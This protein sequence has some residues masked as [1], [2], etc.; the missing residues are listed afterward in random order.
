MS[1]YSLRYE[2]ERITQET[3]IKPSVFFDLVHRSE[4]AVHEEFN[5]KRN[6]KNVNMLM[7]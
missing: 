6:N 2:R 7:T 4:L 1:I 5:F 3:V